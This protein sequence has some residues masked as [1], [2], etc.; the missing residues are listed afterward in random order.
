[1]RPAPTHPP[2]R[3]PGSRSLHPAHVHRGVFVRALYAREIQRSRPG[4]RPQA[5]PTRER[6][7]CRRDGRC[8][9]PDAL[10]QSARSDAPARTLH[11]ADTGHAPGLRHF[12]KAYQARYALAGL[13]GFCGLAAG[14][15][16]RLSTRFRAPA[17]A[18]VLTLCVWAD[19]QW[20]FTP[21]YWK[22]DSRAVVAWLAELVPK[23]STVLTAPDYVSGILS[24]YAHL[25]AAPVNLV[26][27]DAVAWDSVAPAALLMTRLHHVPDP[28]SL[29]ER[30]RELAGP[31]VR[32]DTVGGY[33]ILMRIDKTAQPG[34]R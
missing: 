2:G 10:T 7:Q 15:L 17:T 27:V 11:R 29:R 23:G 8:P 28:R 16:N 24:Y 9:L 25:Q 3:S 34:R 5:P 32:E 14:G 18:A 30:F 26:G 12:R 31:G 33:Q 6:P 1:M 20:Y 19:A 13:V 22:D 4:G 21:R